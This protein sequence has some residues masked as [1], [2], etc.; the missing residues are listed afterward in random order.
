[1]PSQ[2]AA[3]S[4]WTA[5]RG[6]SGPNAYSLQ[7]KIPDGDWVVVGSGRD[8]SLE[9][10]VL[11]M[12]TPHIFRVRTDWEQ[13]GKFFTSYS[14]QFSFE[15]ERPEIRIPNFLSPNEDGKND[16]WRIDHLYWYPG[17]RVR[18]F[19]RWGEL[20]FES[21]NYRNDWK[22]EI[23]GV[24]DTYFFELNT[25]KGVQKGWIQVMGKR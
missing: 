19:N 23:K 12:P 14:D 25:G 20:V 3:I 8:T 16:V 10:S 1:M 9:F 11:P 5:Y 21:D 6:N 13:S 22:P 24:Q 15:I 18:I 7:M 2:I 17:T 4:R